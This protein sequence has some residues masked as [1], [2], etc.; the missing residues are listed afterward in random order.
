MEW[1]NCHHNGR[2][3]R[4]MAQGSK[5]MK[6]AGLGLVLSFW[7]ILALI[8]ALTVPSVLAYS[9]DNQVD[10]QGSQS[11]MNYATSS[12]ESIHIETIAEKIERI[13]G[14]Y[15]LD[16]KKLSAIIKCESHFDPN[17]HNRTSVENSWGLVQIN[18]RAHDLTKQQAIDPEF[19]ITF[20]AEHWT[21]RHLM[22]V[23]CS[24]GI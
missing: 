1:E 5:I 4:K 18:L 21:Q 12:V 19:A 22:W 13:A 6:N 14:A 2:P 15:N 10:N 9:V 23:V 16:P 7:V 3:K 17:A 8:K 20:L 11:T 24:Q